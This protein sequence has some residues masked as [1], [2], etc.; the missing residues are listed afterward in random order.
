MEQQKQVEIE[1]AAISDR[2][3]KIQ[4][5]HSDARDKNESLLQ[6]LERK[7]KQEQKA[8]LTDILEKIQKK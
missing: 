3:L 8:K 6:D 5:A 1:H 7:L 2:A 4:E